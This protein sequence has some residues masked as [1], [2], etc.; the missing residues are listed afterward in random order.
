[1]VV[2]LFQNFNFRKDLCFRFDNALGN[3]V[4]FLIKRPVLCYRPCIRHG[5]FKHYSAGV[6][7]YLIEYLS[8]IF[9]FFFF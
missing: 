4:V 9:F 8:V 2:E 1:M 6:T 3:G 5:L 7:E